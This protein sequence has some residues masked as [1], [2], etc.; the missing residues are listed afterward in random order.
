MEASPQLVFREIDV[1]RDAETCI[2]F[3]A[4]SFACSFGSDERFYQEAGPGCQHYLD[5]LRRRNEELPGS[6]VH[7]WLDDRIVGQVE[8]RLHP[9]RADV[10]RVLLFYLEPEHRGRGLAAQLD[11]YAIEI[12]SGAGCSRASLRVSPTNEPAIRFY[13]RQGW[14]DRGPDPD[15]PEVHVFDRSW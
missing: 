9:Q 3:R 15:H 13:R 8:L 11:G 4:D 12:L 1:E 14:I 5:V 7:A 10:G 2:Q 6:C